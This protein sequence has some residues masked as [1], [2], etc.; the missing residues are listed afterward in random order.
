MALALALGGAAGYAL[1]RTP[2]P[3]REALVAAP[4]SALRLQIASEPVGATVELDGVELGV[5]PL[6]VEHPRDGRLH[7]LQLTHEGFETKV[8]FWTADVDQRLRFEL[9]AIPPPEP[10]RVQA[11]ETDAGRDAAAVAGLERVGDGRDVVVRAHH[12]VRAGASGRDGDDRL[13]RDRVEVEV[14]REDALEQRD[15]NLDALE[16]RP[17]RVEERHEV[18]LAAEEVRGGARH[19][20][21]LVDVEPNLRVLDRERDG[22]AH[23]LEVEGEVERTRRDHAAFDAAVDHDVGRRQVVEGLIRGDAVH[24]VDHRGHAVRGLTEVDAKADRV[25]LG[26]RHAHGLDEDDDRAVREGF[27]DR[28]A[29]VE[30]RRSRREK[31]AEAVVDARRVVV[32]V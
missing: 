22:V 19:A 15:R 9:R 14:E 20:G 30:R 18:D 28:S 4:A 16:K 11:P 13:R 17:E 6:D 29:H 8:E 10:T 2:E 5:T 26:A 24:A 25:L 23:D 21:H 7:R 3:P 27:F 32:A 12:A 31:A 1:L